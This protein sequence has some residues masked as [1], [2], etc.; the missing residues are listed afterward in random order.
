MLA[1]ALLLSSSA[2]AVGI[3]E[4]CQDLADDK[5]ADYDEQQQQDF[6]MN[7]YALG[8]S[9]SGVHA[10]IPHKAG[11]GM[12]GVRLGGLPPLPC[13]RRFALDWTK[14]EDTNK[15]PVLPTITAS[16]AFETPWEEVVPYAEAG[17]LAP[18]PVAGTRNLT[19]QAAIGVGF[20]LGDSA[21]LGVRAH[22]A[23]LRTIGDIA[24][25]IT[26]DDPVEMDLYLGSTLGV[27]AMGGYQIG[28]VTP[29]VMVGLLD[30]S[31][32][33]YVGDSGVVTNNLHPYLGPEY[34][35][36][37]DMLF[38][39]ERLRIGAEYYGA[40]GGHRT[41]GDATDEAGF[42]GYG[43][44]HTLRVRIGVEL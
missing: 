33:F 20:A 30:A 42:A 35:V 9:F 13:R 36:G 18:V 17:F 39:D 32:F 15:S 37:A 19:F 8:A 40:P 5:P 2:R 1:L 10:P 27:Q 25:P 3:D 6:L 14:T 16:Y 7:Y 44:I 34:A 23:V 43:R 22:G 28:S 26:E 11:R 38:V 29:Y 21:Q 24:T 12:I 41:L 31:T 4:A